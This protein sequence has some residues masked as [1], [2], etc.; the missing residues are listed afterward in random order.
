MTKYSSLF[1]NQT[2]P[3]TNSSPL[4]NIKYNISFLPTSININYTSSCIS[5]NST[6]EH[7]PKLKNNIDSKKSSFLAKIKAKLYN[8]YYK[9]IHYYYD[10]TDKEKIFHYASS[11]SFYNIFSIIPM[12]LVFISIFTTFPLFNN[13]INS[14]KEFI[15]DNILLDNTNDILTMI[16]GFLL[17]GKEM[18]FIGFLV[19][20]VSSFFFF[21]NFDDIS[22]RIFIAKKRSL[23]DSFIIYWLLI[24]LI[25]IFLVTSIYFGSSLSTKYW[26]IFSSFSKF[27]PMLTAWLTFAILFRIAA[28]KSIRFTVLALSSMLGAGIWYL[29]KSLFVYYMGYNQFYKNIYGSIS[30]IMFMLLWI[31]VSWL[32]ILVSMRFCKKLDDRFPLHDTR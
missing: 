15:L 8:E 6:I 11:L 25:P 29:F 28:N 2:N 1:T 19:A 24:T 16:D 10:F 12:L 30:I 27:I 9:C 4:D 7:N 23:F 17:N 18:G 13:Q 20:L 5:N 14:L 21:R 26:D 3:N 32:V 31:Y 22:A